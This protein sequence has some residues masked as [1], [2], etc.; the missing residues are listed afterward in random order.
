MK[1]KKQFNMSIEGVH[2]HDEAILNKMRFLDVC[3]YHGTKS[4][5]SCILEAIREIFT[6]SDT[7]FYA[8]FGIHYNDYMNYL[9]TK[10]EE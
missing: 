8:V 6:V 10:V 3:V 2:K 5:K 1:R 9:Y 7:A 4:V